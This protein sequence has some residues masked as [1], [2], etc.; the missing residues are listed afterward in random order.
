ML[1]FIHWKNAGKHDHGSL[2]KDPS[3][4]PQG[5]RITCIGAEHN[6]YGRTLLDIKYFGRLGL[7]HPSSKPKST[8][9]SRPGDLLVS[10]L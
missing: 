4:G 3:T 7:H 9:A 8:I 1:R 5:D 10:V 2:E 6:Y